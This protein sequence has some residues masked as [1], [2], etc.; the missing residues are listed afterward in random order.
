MAPKN[1]Q[2]I[3]QPQGE[4]SRLKASSCFSLRI[5]AEAHKSTA[6]SRR[7]AAVRIQL[8]ACSANRRLQCNHRYA[9]DPVPLTANSCF[10][11][12]LTNYS[13]PYLLSTAQ[14]LTLGPRTPSFRPSHH[15]IAERTTKWSLRSETPIHSIQRSWELSRRMLLVFNCYRRISTR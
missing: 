7:T 15:W 5:Y 14:I 3:Q 11:V 2:E 4:S 6:P 8:E 12:S 1:L 9:G 10:F 13:Y